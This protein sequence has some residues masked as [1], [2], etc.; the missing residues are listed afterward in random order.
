MKPTLTL[1]IFSTLIRGKKLKMIPIC[2]FFLIIQVCVV[3]Q[4]ACFA[5]EQQKQEK[6]GAYIAALHVGDCENVCDS[7]SVDSALSSCIQ[8]HLYLTLNF[9]DEHEKEI[10][11]NGCEKL[12]LK[13][14]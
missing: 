3:Q 14:L 9:L 8:T 1:Q 7:G 4:H 11:T 6:R 5:R 2:R 12:I 10:N 13:Q